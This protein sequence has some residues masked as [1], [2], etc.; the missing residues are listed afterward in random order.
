ML[1]QVDALIVPSRWEGFGL[2]ALEAMRNSKPVIANCVG[3][4]A[5]LIED[6]VN[7]LFLN[8][9]DIPACRKMLLSLT[10]E[11]TARMGAA[12]FADFKQN[13]TW[14]QCYGKWRQLLLATASKVGGKTP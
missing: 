14:S 3:G 10:R 5:E 12:S 4:L 8:I 7:G 11:Q 13:Y 6:G 2:V 9:E 1:S